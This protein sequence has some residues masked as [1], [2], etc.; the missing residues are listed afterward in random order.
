MLL[1]GRD[2]LRWTSAEMGAVRGA[3]IGMVFQDPLTSLNPA[4]RIGAQ[5]AE[6]SAPTSRIAS[7]R[8]SAGDRAAGARRRRRPGAAGRT[9]I[10][11]ISAAACASAC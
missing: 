6:T 7:A 1:D 2:L 9:T 3:R 10:R 8:R 4:L 11:I 5:I